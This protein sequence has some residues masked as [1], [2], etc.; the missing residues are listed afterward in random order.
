MSC[1]STSQTNDQ[2]HSTKRGGPYKQQYC[3][4]DLGLCLSKYVTTDDTVDNIINAYF[5]KEKKKVPRTTMFDNLRAEFK[6]EDRIITLRQIKEV[7]AKLGPTEKENY[8]SKVSKA[9]EVLLQTK[10]STKKKNLEQLHSHNRTLT[11]D[12]ERYLLHL[13]KILQF[14]GHGVEKDELLFCIS[15][16]AHFDDGNPSDED[17]CVSQSVADNFL[18]RH[19]GEVKLRGSSGLD[20]QRAAQANDEVREAEFVKLDCYVRLLYNLGLIPWKC[21]TDIPSSNVYNMDEV[22]SDTT[23]RRG[24]KVT[25]AKDANR[26]YNITPEG[27]RMPF[28]VSACITSR[29]DGKYAEPGEKIY[30]GAPP[31]VIIHS[32][33]KDRK[34]SKRSSKKKAKQQRKDVRKV[35]DRFLEHLAPMCEGAQDAADAF[36]KNNVYG[37]E[38]FATTNGSM[39]QDSMLPYAEHFVRNKMAGPHAN[40]PAVL[41]LDGHSSR[42]DLSALYYLIE[43]GVF[44]FFLPSH[45]SIWSQPN[46]TGPNFRL[47]KCIAKFQKKYRRR[48]LTKKW[49]VSDWNLVFRLAWAEYLAQER[50]DFYAMNHNR[51]TAAYEKTGIYPFNPNS[52]TW[53]HAITTLGVSAEEK[54]SEPRV[55][56]YEPVPIETCKRE[57][58]TSAEE[59]CLLAGRTPHLPDI[60]GAASNKSNKVIMAAMH[61]ANVMLARWREHCRHKD[62]VPKIPSSVASDSATSHTAPDTT[63]QTSRSSIA[64]DSDPMEELPVISRIAMSHTAP[65][66]TLRTSRSSVAADSDPMEESPVGSRIGTS[67]TAQATT[68]RTS[69]NSV[70]ADSD[71]MEESPVISRIT[72]SHSAPDTALRTSSSS[73]ASDSDPMEEL[74]VVSCTAT[75]HTAPDT[76]LQTSPSSVAA[77]SDPMEESPVVSCIATSHTAPD[78]SLRT[79][80]SSVAA[81]SD[82]MEESPVISRITTSHSAPDTALR[83]SSSS[84][85]SDSDPMEESPVISR[86]TT[87]HSAPDTALQ[88]SSS[89]VAADSGPMEESLVISPI[90]TSHT[91]QDTIL[92][93]SPSSVAAD[94]DRME[95]SPVVSRIATSHTAPDTTLRTSPSSVAAD[96]DRMEESPVV[97]RIA[98]SHTAQDTILRM[99][100]SPVAANSGPII[101]SQDIASDITATTLPKKTPS[102]FAKTLQEKLSLKIIEFI[103]CDT[104]LLP[105][106]KALTEKEKRQQHTDF[107]LSQTSAGTVLEITCFT[108]VENGIR[109][110]NKGKAIKVTPDEWSIF[111]HDGSGKTIPKKARQAELQDLNMFEVIGTL[112]HSVQSE[113]DKRSQ[114]EAERRKRKRDQ[115]RREQL[116]KL[117][118]ERQRSEMLRQEYEKLVRTMRSHRPYSF[119]EFLNLEKKLTTP[120]TCDVEIEGQLIRGIATADGNENGAF[121]LSVHHA[122]TESLF[123]H[124]PD[125]GECSEGTKR[126]KKNSGGRYVPTHMSENGLNAIIILEGKDAKQ[127]K[128]MAMQRQK[129][130]NSEKKVLENLL[131]DVQKYKERNPSNYGDVP[132]TKTNC[133]LYYRLFDGPVPSRTDHAKQ[134]DFLSGKNLDKQKLDQ[135]MASKQ[136]RV[137]FIAAEIEKTVAYI[138]QLDQQAGGGTQAIDNNGDEENEDAS[139]HN[140]GDEEENE[141]D[142]LEEEDVVDD[143]V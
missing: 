135:Q 3:D 12:Q 94:S 4:V 100:S 122:L 78:T 51:T 44:P 142:C 57:I 130:F 47:H 80:P 134:V 30:D 120:F 23:K 52:P 123:R 63:L 41:L 102:N 140:D 79:S 91:A 131:N 113:A 139:V 10:A 116:A 70:A 26:Q 60:A 5:E 29:A 67:H 46:D 32:K 58:L 138:Q 95:E 83:T 86:I 132:A 20:P 71:P 72:T 143:E 55:R 99:S 7:F 137:H 77:D 39:T 31:P 9:I 127:K 101:P 75:S 36:R 50:N 117:E 21:Y 13:C 129:E 68:L 125:S 34:D 18:K 35:S 59:E 11:P 42:W 65:D 111:L 141:N 114:K 33:G 90:T 61:H 84:V 133:K 81:D 106:P 126:R 85:A 104:N 92:R 17:D 27:D 124:K 64:A 98:T 96:S 6:F 103:P 109:K 62:T 25:D 19:E 110:S 49:N 89:S 43:N 54:R 16:I 48:L 108:T 121:N 119:D 45:T 40:E 37:F 97:S 118:A 15:K 87:S 73:V 24:K 66:T 53:R 2:Q 115:E 128:A 28:H 105:K 8:Q 56:G 38:V 1:T 82:P 14:S 93:M 88:T 112:S 22:A 107:I 69:P 76:I 74:L 136:Q